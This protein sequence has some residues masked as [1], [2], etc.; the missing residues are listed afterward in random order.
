MEP[1]QP[2]KCKT[3]EIKMFQC[4]TTDLSLTTKLLIAGYKFFHN[5]AMT[6]SCDSSFFYTIRFI[7]KHTKL[8]MTYALPYLV[9]GICW[10]LFCTF[11]LILLITFDRVTSSPDLILTIK[12][13]ISWNSSWSPE[14]SLVIPCYNLFPLLSTAPIFNIHYT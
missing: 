2:S 11:L 9:R 6:F 3:I 4:L 5:L 7:F 13:L 1:E 8:S 14:V 12:L 10:Q